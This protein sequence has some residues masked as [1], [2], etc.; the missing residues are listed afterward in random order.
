M[1]QYS[2]FVYDNIGNQYRRKNL[3]LLEVAKLQKKIKEDNEKSFKT[4]LDNLIKNKEKHPYNISLA[5]YNKDEKNFLDAL[6][7]SRDIINSMIEMNARASSLALGD[8]FPSLVQD[9]S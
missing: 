7:I 3:Y 9:F 8:L 2:E 1:G 4:E 5:K 6:N